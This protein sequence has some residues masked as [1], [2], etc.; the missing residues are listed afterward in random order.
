MP[1]DKIILK[2][3]LAWSVRLREAPASD[4]RQAALNA[5]LAADP[6]HRRAFALIERGVDDLAGAHLLRGRRPRRWPFR[7]E[8]RAFLLGGVAATGIVAV[9]GAQLF[10]P[11][12]Y[13][14]AIGERLLVRTD[15]GADILLN[16]ASRLEV[17]RSYDVTRL[18]L[19]AGEAFF[20]VTGAQRGPIV[21]AGGRTLE[22]AQAQF[23][24]RCL[25]DEDM[26][27]LVTSG[28][29]RVDGASG[30]GFAL[31]EGERLEIGD[32]GSRVSRL[33]EADIA[34]MLAWR[35]GELEFAG[36]PLAA[37]AAEVARY[38][39]V[40]FI[41]DQDVQDEAIWARFRTSDADHFL[42][43]LRSRSGALAIERRGSMIHIARGPDLDTEPR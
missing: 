5:W 34:R 12:H 38:A 16:T 40:T 39:P 37:A 28:A 33:G 41:I 23:A 29:V 8:R 43:L 17:R 10:A 11:D 3:A 25:P 15:I 30:G 4:E 26:V 21:E 24:V 36:E 1:R 42:R 31:A 20:S 32:T 6:R 27:V 13:Q 35:T 19:R 22:A 18:R 14:T 7:A 2:E 9:L